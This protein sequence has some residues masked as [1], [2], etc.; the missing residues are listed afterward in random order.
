MFLFLD[1]GLDCESVSISSSTSGTRRGQ[2]RGGVA[3]QILG[4]T[5][6]GIKNPSRGTSL[7]KTVMEDIPEQLRTPKIPQVSFYIHLFINISSTQWKRGLNRFEG[8]RCHSMQ[9]TKSKE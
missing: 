1:L 8:T 6:P 7:E 4:M 9:F 2:I 5:I 3:R